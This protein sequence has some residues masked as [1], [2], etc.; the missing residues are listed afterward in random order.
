MY[1]RPG[2]ENVRFESQLLA[3][4]I[5]YQ[6]SLSLYLMLS[7]TVDLKRCKFSRSCHPGCKYRMTFLK[8]KN[9]QVNGW[10]IKIFDLIC[11]LAHMWNCTSIPLRPT[12]FSKGVWMPV[13]LSILNSVWQI[14]SIDIMWS[15][16][17]CH[18]RHKGR[19]AG[20]NSNNNAAVNY[21][22]K[23][24]INWKFHVKEM[25]NMDKETGAS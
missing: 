1:W 8:I 2:R 17:E 18:K 3:L 24:K 13:C 4:V 7:S 14:N 5:R 10:R 6:D 21:F 20:H 19:V 16:N 22:S 11:C 23:M 25:N 9:I 12:S 15:K